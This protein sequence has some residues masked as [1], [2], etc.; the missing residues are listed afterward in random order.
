MT[1]HT[2]HPDVLIH[3]LQADC[4]RCQEH[5]LHPEW[6]EDDLRLLILTYPKTSLDYEARER[7]RLDTIV[8]DMEAQRIALL[9][10]KALWK[11]RATYA[12]QRLSDMEE[13]LRRLAERFERHRDETENPESLAWDNA[14]YLARQLLQEGS[15][16]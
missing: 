11:Q 5:A 13:G 12:E 2:Y 10:Q 8:S 1:T 14:A 4:P 3:G 16:E 6:L 9:D 7:L 15:S